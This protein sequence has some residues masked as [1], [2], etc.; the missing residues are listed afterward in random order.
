MENLVDDQAACLILT[1]EELED[2]TMSRP[3]YTEVSAS[4]VERW[5]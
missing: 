3:M 5:R 1:V 4:S 2:L